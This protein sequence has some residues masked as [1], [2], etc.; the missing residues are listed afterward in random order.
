MDRVSEKDIETFQERL[1]PRVRG[2]FG[3][4]PHLLLYDATNFFTFLATTNDRADLAQR[5]HSKAKRHDLRQ[6]GL[7]LLVSRDFQIP[8]FHRT[9]PGNIPDTSL[10]PEL[11]KELLA[12]YETFVG[13]R[14]D[15]T[16]VFDKGNVTDDVMEQLVVSQTPFVA[17]L[18]ANRHRDLLAT[19]LDQFQ[20]LPEFPGT[21][22]FTT[23]AEVWGQLCQVVVTYTESF[24]TQQLSR[25]TQNLVKI[26][27]KLMD[28]EKSLRQWRKGK[29]RG[30]K[31]TAASPISRRPSKT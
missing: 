3:I 20:D 25:V 7:A 15:A 16:L 24:F 29:G 1:V 14:R 31:P 17:A 23:Q 6:I 27:K 4:D 9:Y 30:K 22:A 11:S 19:P 10:F 5:G 2:A 18:S 12:R 28:L 8:L 26:Q 13:K 21:R